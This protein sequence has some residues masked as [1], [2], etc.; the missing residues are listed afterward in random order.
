MF[1]L[2]PQLEKDCIVLGDYPLSRLLLL[3]DARY[4]WFVLVPRREAITEIYQLEEEEQ[5]QLL[6]E[7]TQLGRFLMEGFSGDK[8]NIGALGNVVPQL[9]I[10]H[11]VRYKGD[12]T[13]PGPVWGVGT[14]LPFRQD[15]I[16]ILRQRCQ[17]LGITPAV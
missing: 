9:H 12:E 11:I 3:N 14:A 2:H 13:W 16:E 6:R 1:K 5:Q 4:P 8:L 15:E 17:Q 10:H 7:S